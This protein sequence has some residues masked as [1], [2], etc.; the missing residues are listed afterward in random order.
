MSF[1]RAGLQK[2]SGLHVCFVGEGPKY[3]PEEPEGIQELLD[4]WY[5]QVQMGLG[6]GEVTLFFPDGLL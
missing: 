4:V 1:S 6:P 5:L 2:L 3:E